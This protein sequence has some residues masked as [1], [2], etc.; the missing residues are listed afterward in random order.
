M[1]D[2]YLAYNY[3]LQNSVKAPAAEAVTATLTVPLKYHHNI[4]QQGTFFRNLRNIGVT[5]DHSA[6]PQKAATS[7]Q[8]PSG[9]AATARIDEPEEDS[10]IQWYTVPNYQDAEEGDSTW[11]VKGKDQAGVDRAVKQI[12]EAIKQAERATSVGFLILPDR[13]SFPRE[14]M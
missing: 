9:D 12:E 1:F 10:G 13:S 4:S 8:P 5:V 6:F 11:T 14:L 7:P 3:L 2:V